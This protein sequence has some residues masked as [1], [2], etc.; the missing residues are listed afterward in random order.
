MNT[1]NSQANYDKFFSY[2][3]NGEWWVVSQPI[4]GI[5]D[6]I[7][8]AK[9]LL[10]RVGKKDSVLDNSKFFPDITMDTRFEEVSSSIWS[11]IK[12]NIDHNSD[13]FLER[14][15]I[16]ICPNEIANESILSKIKEVNSKFL[17]NKKKIVLEL[18][19]QFTEKEISASN[20]KFIDLINS[21]IEFAVDDYGLGVLDLDLIKKTKASYLK[22]DKS[23]CTEGFSKNQNLIKQALLFCNENNIISIAEGVETEG[24]KDIL[25]D[26]GFDL[27]QGF[28]VE[29]PTHIFSL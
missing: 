16:N 9:E 22:F 10:I 15:F 25:L 3:S 18:S 2:I 7:P 8:I 5:K 11:L 1:I 27:V 13:I 23:L 26:E 20:N 29:K 17:L 21:G 6:D 28:L 12:K 14:T 4:V 24:Q 19:E